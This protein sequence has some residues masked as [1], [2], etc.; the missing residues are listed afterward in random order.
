MFCIKL[1][2]WSHSEPLRAISA[3]VMGTAVSATH[4]AG[5]LSTEY[6]VVEAN[7]R[8]HSIS[9]HGL[10]IR[11]DIACSVASHASVLLCFIMLVYVIALAKRNSQSRHNSSADNKYDV[12]QRTK[13]GQETHHWMNLT[14]RVHCDPSSILCHPSENDG[15]SASEAVGSRAPVPSFSKGPLDGIGMSDSGLSYYD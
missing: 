5:M 14:A 12:P 6:Q 13:D 9:T 8:E 15:S 2:F 10:L 4:Y 11:A 7:R 1:T 3:S